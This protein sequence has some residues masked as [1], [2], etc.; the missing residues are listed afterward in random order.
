MQLKLALFSKR[1][2]IFSFLEKIDRFSKKS[3][4]FSVTTKRTEF[5]VENEWNSEISQNVQTFGCFKKS[6]MGSPK[7]FEIKLK[8]LKLWILL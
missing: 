3:W 6:Y 4:N 7:E 2:K 1:S 5:S 8:Q